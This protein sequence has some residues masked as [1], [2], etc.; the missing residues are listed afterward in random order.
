MKALS[1]TKMG[2]GP[3]FQVNFLNE[4]KNQISKAGTNYTAEVQERTKTSHE[5]PF[6][7]QIYKG[8]RAADN[9]T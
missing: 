7:I 1:I 8:K 9:S 3:S 6:K 5:I 2:Q 4:I